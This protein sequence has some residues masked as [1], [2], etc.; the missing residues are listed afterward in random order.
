MGSRAATAF[1]I[2]ACALVLLLYVAQ[3]W[4]EEEEGAEEPRHVM[5]L[6]LGGT[7]TE[8]TTAPTIGADYAYRAK[9]AV[10]VGAILDHAAGDINTTLVGPAVF[11]RIQSFEVTFAV[12]LEFDEGDTHGVMRLGGGYEFKF[13]RGFVLVPAAYFDSQRGTDE[14]PALVWGVNFGKEF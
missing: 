13:S 9:P 10:S 12:A 7:T 8:E 3:A 14:K 5:T 11:F 1:L 4:A 6:F 2:A